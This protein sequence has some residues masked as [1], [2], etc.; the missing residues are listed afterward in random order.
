MWDD[1][2]F[3]PQILGQLLSTAT[4]LE[5]LQVY[6]HRSNRNRYD[7]TAYDSTRMDQLALLF[8]DETASTIDADSSDR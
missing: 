3:E 6:T 5:V 1:P 4:D 8:T 2:P 7:L